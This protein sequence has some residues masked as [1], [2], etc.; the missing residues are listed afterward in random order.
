MS[1]VPRRLIFEH[2]HVFHVPGLP[3]WKVRTPWQFA[4]LF[5]SLWNGRSG[6]ANDD[7]HFVRARYV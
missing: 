7:L 1:K 2:P 5:V 4:V 3:G 6:R